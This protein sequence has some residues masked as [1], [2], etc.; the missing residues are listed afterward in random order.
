MQA[1]SLAPAPEEQPRKKPAVAV[2]ESSALQ[3]AQMLA[4]MEATADPVPLKPG[5]WQGCVSAATEAAL[6]EAIKP[7]DKQGPLANL[8]YS[9]DTRPISE[10]RAD[11]GVFKRD[12]DMMYYLQ[13]HGE[14]LETAPASYGCLHPKWQK[15]HKAKQLSTEE[16]SALWQVEQC[17]M[18]PI[19]PKTSHHMTSLDKWTIAKVANRVDPTC[20]VA[21]CEPFYLSETTIT[22]QSPRD[23]SDTPDKHE[24]FVTHLYTEA[25][26]SPALIDPARYHQNSASSIFT[27]LLKRHGYAEPD[28]N[29]LRTH[30]HRLRGKVLRQ[31]HR[32]RVGGKVAAADEYRISGEGLQRLHTAVF[33]EADPAKA[34]QLGTF[35]AM[36]SNLLLRPSQ[37]CRLG[38]DSLFISKDF[39][40]SASFGETDLV[41]VVSRGQN[42]SGSTVDEHLFLMHQFDPAAFN[43]MWWLSAQDVFLNDVKLPQQP[44]I[45][46]DGPFCGQ[47]AHS[48]VEMA[49]KGM[50][51]A[52]AESLPGFPQ[53]RKLGQQ[54]PVFGR[55]P[56]LPKS[57][58]ITQP[59]VANNLAQF[60]LLP[61]LQRIRVKGPDADKLSDDVLCKLLRNGM[62]CSY[63]DNSV[64][65]ENL[66]NVSKHQQKGLS[67]G[68]VRYGARKC[69]KSL[70]MRNAGYP[71]VEEDAQGSRGWK[72]THVPTYEVLD[73]E[74][75]AQKGGQ[76]L[77][78]HHLVDQLIM[79]GLEQGRAQA[80]M[81]AANKKEQQVLRHKCIKHL[82]W[83]HAR[84]WTFFALAALYYPT[85]K[86][87]RIFTDHPCFQSAEAVRLFEEL[88]I[89]LVQ[90]SF[91]T[92]AK[93]YMHLCGP[94]G[95]HL[96]HA[97]KMQP[98]H[99]KLPGNNAEKR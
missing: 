38:R 47:Q 82:D 28:Y 74:F 68:S 56:V 58:D 73:S 89:P 92:G 51:D 8:P 49:A 61:A 12:R 46:Q 7:T 5:E 45:A 72:R 99:A 10:Q 96:L 41:N 43:P 86:Q 77:Q 30:T 14:N 34:L 44:Y 22:R 95:K 97:A 55:I 98:G 13:K 88:W 60:M 17:S 25:L 50:T 9:I 93:V 11:P 23:M 36:I 65:D 3:D 57:D 64:S 24:A 76:H 94:S 4:A 80:E 91:S 79:P 21:T 31:L 85:Q 78:L 20:L 75:L 67:L 16:W 87:H 48:F 90:D 37:G 42:K 29:P 15:R 1:A 63:K 81:L 18:E 52:R 2:E 6:Q 62:C 32:D 59:C 53:A 54:Q 40:D 71:S 35:V 83:L 70:A 27:K 33:D 66:S 26:S 39:A 69:S 19:N 84:K